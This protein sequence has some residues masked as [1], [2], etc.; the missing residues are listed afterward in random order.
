MEIR[1]FF[2]PLVRGSRPRHPNGIIGR[3]ENQ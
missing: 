2:S 3:Q 1:A